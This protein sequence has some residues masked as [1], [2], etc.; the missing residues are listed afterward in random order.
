MKHVLLKHKGTTT[1]NVDNLEVSRRI[2]DHAFSVYKSKLVDKIISEYIVATKHTTICS[3][4]TR[5]KKKGSTFIIPR[6][7]WCHYCIRYAAVKRIPIEFDD[8]TQVGAASINI[9]LNNTHC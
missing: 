5:V 1:Q 2:R 9:V 7:R 4:A 8:R 3:N 6:G